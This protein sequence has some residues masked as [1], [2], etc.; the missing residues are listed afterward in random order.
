MHGVIQIFTKLDC[1]PVAASKCDHIVSP[2]HIIPLR[3]VMQSTDYYSQILAKYSG[4]L[5]LL[6]T[7]DNKNDLLYI[8]YMRQEQTNLTLDGDVKQK[9]EEAKATTNK[10]ITVI[11]EDLVRMFLPEWYKRSGFKNGDKK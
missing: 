2:A 8:R 3:T 6:Q 10:P 11:I 7:I 5:L 4:K 1:T 9:L